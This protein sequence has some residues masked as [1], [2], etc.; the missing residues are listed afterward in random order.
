MCNGSNQL[1]SLCNHEEAD[2]RICVHVQDALKKGAWDILV[3]TV[4]TDVVVILVSM[5]FHFSHVFPD[6][7]ICVG[8][9]TGKHFKY[10]SINSMCQYLGKQKSRTLPFFH[11]FTGCNTTSQFLCKGKICVGVLEIIFRGD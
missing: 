4:D 8:F 7:N 6:V 5:Y 11:T 1:M 3:S 2:S 10:Y 9:G